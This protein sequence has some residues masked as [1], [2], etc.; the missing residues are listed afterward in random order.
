MT[1]YFRAALVGMLTTLLVAV[2]SLAAT[3][4]LSPM[5]HQDIEYLT[6]DRGLDEP[7]AEGSQQVFLHPSDEKFAVVESAAVAPEWQTR[8]KQLYASVMDRGKR[9]IGLKCVSVSVEEPVE[10]AARGTSALKVYGRDGSM[11]R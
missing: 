1:I 3:P 9:A 2:V 4:G 8:I 6:W 5:W 11:M 10:I 7:L